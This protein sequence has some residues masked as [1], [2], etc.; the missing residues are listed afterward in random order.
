MVALK[1]HTPSPRVS[2][3][4]RTRCF[5]GIVLI[6]A[7]ALLAGCGT[8]NFLNDNDRLRR[9]NLELRTQVDQLQKNIDLR[10][11]QIQTLEQR[12]S[13]TT[14]PAIEGAHVPQ[15]AALQLD[16]YTG[17]I[18]TNHDG[19]DDTVRIYLKPLDQEGRFIPVAG[20]AVAQVVAIQ[21][22]EP[23]KLLAE[24]VFEPAEFNQAYRTGLTGTHY[25][26]ELPLPSPLPKGLKSATLKVTLTDAA[27]GAQL[28]A[29]QAINITSAKQ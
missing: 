2:G 26:L 15:A 21:P 29:E 27:T 7:L 18:D 25:T 4:T 19:V 9:E 10:L 16:R 22:G 24:K 3:G 8:K 28:V 14:R 11:A 6:T 13:P 12:V 23:P 20:R 5:R 17:A 1:K